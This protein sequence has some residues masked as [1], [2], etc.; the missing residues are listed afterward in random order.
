MSTAVT[1]LS[2]ILLLPPPL[3]ELWTATEQQTSPKER[4]IHRLLNDLHEYQQEGVF[5]PGE[6]EAI[7][8][9]ATDTLLSFK[10]SF[11]ASAASDDWYRNSVLHQV[12]QSLL[13]SIAQL[14]DDLVQ[15]RI[16]KDAVR[17]LT[18]GKTAAAMMQKPISWRDKVA[19]AHLETGN[20]QSVQY[21][22]N[23]WPRRIY[24]EQRARY[25]DALKG[26]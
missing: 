15:D 1:S 22:A 8:G 3:Q 6:Y 20:G 7:M 16:Y 25:S 19:D 14:R 4:A 24:R 5:A 13:K 2:P 21:K 9:A 10:Y 26:V 11:T 17:E 12:G 18:I 23:T